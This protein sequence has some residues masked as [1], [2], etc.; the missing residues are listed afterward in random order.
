MLFSGIGG[1]GVMVLGEIICNVAGKAGYNATF[2]PFYGQEKRGGRTMCHIVISDS[3]ESPII[4]EARVMLVMDERSLND[5]EDLVEPEKG[6]L[7]VNSSMID[8]KPK[9]D[10]IQVKNYPF[11]DI[12]TDIGNAKGANM[13]ALGALMKFL[14]FLSKE[15]AIDEVKKAFAAKQQFIESNI[16]AFEA[17]YDYEG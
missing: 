11:Y 5:F 9:R 2:A 16:K 7:L 1:Q 13:V 15:A 3:M 17:G 14:P 12:A 10:D 4:S 8:T 6:V